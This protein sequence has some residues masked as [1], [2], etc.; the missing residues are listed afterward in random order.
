M[1]TWQFR[2]EIDKKIIDALRDSDLFKNHLKKDIKKGEIFPAIRINSIDFYYCGGRLFSFDKD[3]FKTHVKYASVYDYNQNYVNEN[4]LKNMKPIEGF[5]ESYDRIKENCKK[6]TSVEPYGVSKLYKFS[7][8]I[9][10]QNKVVLLDIEISF[11][12]PKEKEE[13]GFQDPQKNTKKRKR[14]M[15]RV[16][17][18]LYNTQDKS[19]HFVEAKH[20]SNGELWSKTKPEV[21]EQVED[22]N[23]QLHDKKDKILEV[24]GNYINLLK[25]LFKDL[26]LD[27][28]INLIPKTGLYIFGYDGDQQKSAEEL[29]HKMK[30]EKIPAYT[31]G[32]P[33]D[34]K[35]DKLW[36]ETCN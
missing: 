16:D 21:I 9:S 2:R 30:Q 10:K 3:G 14:K 7:P 6:Y 22:Y 12:T 18:L 25:E 29:K 19:L 34:I 32:N 35:I 27:C 24:Y 36:K 23:K 8:F 31:I 1:D 28:P 11:K 13:V 26:N 17:I 4:N 33:K 20:F 5:S 15:D